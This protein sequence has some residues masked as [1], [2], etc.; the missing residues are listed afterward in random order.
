MN[1]FINDIPLVI[2]KQSEKVY[3]HKFDLILN[4]PT[5]SLRRKT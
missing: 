3:K 1:I 2:K 5:T 4:P